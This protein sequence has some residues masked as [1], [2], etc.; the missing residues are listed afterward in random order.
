MFFQEFFGVFTNDYTEPFDPA[1]DVS[2]YVGRNA[3]RNAY[4]GNVTLP[5][6]VNPFIP[7]PATPDD[8]NKVSVIWIV[9]LCLMCA[10]MLGFLGWALYKWKI[11]QHN[12]WTLEQNIIEGENQ[13]LVNHSGQTGDED[14]PIGM[15]LKE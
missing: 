6:G 11:A 1:Q 3:I 7:S 2:L 10:I 5:E 8:G 15:E 9:V 12:S 13:R 4:V 14:R